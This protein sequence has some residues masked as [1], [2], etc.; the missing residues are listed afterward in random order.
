M[1]PDASSSVSIRNLSKICVVQARERAWRIGQKRDVTVYRLITRGT[2]EEKVYHRQ[3]YKHFLTNKILKNPQQ[4][5]FFKAKDMKDLFT[6]QDDRE[7]GSTETSHIFSQLSEEVN[8]GIGNGYQDKQGS[9]SSACTGPVVPAKE[10][11]SPGLGASSS[12]SKG[13]EIAG[14]R[15]GE[16]DEESNILKSLFDA[17]GIHASAKL[18]VFLLCIYFLRWYFIIQAGFLSVC[19]VQ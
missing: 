2:I 7:G 5:R 6:L 8:I 9:P 15:N 1:N 3:I 19:R 4:R 10:T 16:L 14:Q 17:Q 13:K 12:N 11:N 18:F